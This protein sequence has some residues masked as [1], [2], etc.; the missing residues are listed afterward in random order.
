M[1]VDPVNARSH[2]AR[3]G[4]ALPPALAEAL[5]ATG[6]GPV[7]PADF[8]P[9]AGGNTNRV[10]RWQARDG[11]LGVK[12]VL[13]GGGTPL[14]PND[15]V[16]EFRALQ[17]LEGTGLAPRPL[18]LC[19]VG[20]GRALI[21]RWV[22][23]P[24]W[25]GDPARLA[26]LLRRLH[27]RPVPPGLRAMAADPLAQGAAMLA[28]LPGD[29]RRAALEALRPAPG[30]GPAG[31]E[32]FLHSDVVP[33][34]IVM[35]P[36]P[37]LIDWQCPARGEAVEDIAVALSPAMRRVYGGPPVDPAE[38]ARFLAAYADPETARR[39]TARA[40]ALHWRMAAYCLWRAAQGGPLA[41]AYAEGFEAELAL[42]SG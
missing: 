38:P 25:D 31:P 9:A 34:N 29:P 7:H 14:F 20:P 28:G 17:A 6:L 33:A 10:W 30:A 5:A 37:V 1:R 32:V 40:P 16:A 35:A 42:L 4:A 41:Q 3:Q 39:F 18:A 23:G 27:A 26:R 15:P 11:A 12:L 13:P 19:P 36:E 8:A 21:Y 2:A 22:E 24:A